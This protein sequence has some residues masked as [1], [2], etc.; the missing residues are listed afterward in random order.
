MGED[1]RDPKNFTFPERPLW[2]EYFMMTAKLAGTM[3]TCLKR[4]VG[5]VVVKNKRII[6]TGFNG[7]PP[8]MPH[9][10]EVGCLIIEEEGTACQRVLHAEHN[11]VLQNSGALEGSTLYTSFLPCLNCMKT[12]ISAKIR[13][14]VFEH[15][16]SQKTKYQL[17]RQFA[18][19]GGIHLR[20]IPEVKVAEIVSRYGV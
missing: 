6:S 17:A 11:A 15:E 20:R 3:G 5:S 2:D 12:I 4:R 9:C 1:Y 19:E 16:S 10:T 8:G 18:E 7:S 14:V 13:E